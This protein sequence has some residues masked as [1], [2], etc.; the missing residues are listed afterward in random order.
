MTRRRPIRVGG[1]QQH[2]GRT[3]TRVPG[4]AGSAALV[5]QLLECGVA[6]VEETF[7]E[8]CVGEGLERGQPALDVIGQRYGLAG[9][10]HAVGELAVSEESGGRRRDD[11]RGVVAIV[12]WSVREQPVGPGQHFGGSHAQRD[13]LERT[14]LEA[15]VRSNRTTL[16]QRLV[17]ERLATRPTGRFALD[18]QLRLAPSGRAPIVG[19]VVVPIVDDKVAPPDGAS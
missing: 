4:V 18:R 2:A 5:E 16:A 15:A 11:V 7:V 10:L 13:V 9:K 14:L 17:A 6:V 1:N 19:R 8:R 12:A 3:A